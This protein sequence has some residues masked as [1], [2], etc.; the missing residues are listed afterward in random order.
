MTPGGSGAVYDRPMPDRS[1]PVNVLLVGS[2]GREHA[3][4][5]KLAQSPRMG[6]FWTTGSAN[7]GIGA[8]ARQVDVPVDFANP[9][10]LKSFCDKNDIGLV[11]IGP[12][13]PLAVGLADA[14][15]AEG[16]VVFGP[17][18]DA[19]RLEA[20]KAWMRTLLRGASVPM[21]EGRSF[22]D[23]SAAKAYLETRTEPHVIKA[24]GLAKGK[25]VLIPETKEEAL[26][27]IERI[28]VRREFGDA[29][30][31]VVIE[32]RLVGWEAS[33]LALV[34][35]RNLFILEPCQD[36]KRLGDND[37]GPNTGGMGAICPG[38]ITDDE[39]LAEVQ[40]DIL[41]PTVDAM[42][43]EG[44]DFLGVLYAGIMVTHA[45]PKLLEYN[46]RFGDPECQAIMPRLEGDLLQAMLDA[47]RRRLD[48]AELSFNAGAT[49][50]VV[51]AADGYPES[52]R[53]GD[54]IE[55]ID[56]ATEL[57]G[58]EVFLAGVAQAADGSLVTNGGRVLSVVAKAE[59]AERARTLA[60]KAAELIRFDGKVMRT[61][62]GQA[63][64]K[65]RAAENPLL[66]W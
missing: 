33:I 38:G 20:D 27:A 15:Q 35:G 25:G 57:D 60:Y 59:D 36:H 5:W 52:P 1:D 58:V 49:C 12:E 53:K 45:G 42:R 65:V 44:M 4:A 51:L 26:E 43:R 55:G 30:A 19:A 17:K 48:E 66:A 46:V 16:R 62:I 8:F 64:V 50:C 24:A 34:D 61:D 13:D 63:N 54:V 7:P 29:G 56:D 9:Y 23:P 32:E 22:T 28:M 40:R 47:G 3:L 31:S 41:V 6:A 18:R 2:G 10:R 21:G 37:T 14:L 39:L 11:V